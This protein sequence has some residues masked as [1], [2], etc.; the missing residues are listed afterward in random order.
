MNFIQGRKFLKQKEFGKALEIFKKIEKKNAK[1]QNIFFYLG[2]VY[3]ELNQYD[4]S[5]DYYNKF[6][7][8]QPNSLSALYNLALVKQ[9]TGKLEEAKAIYFK[10]LSI[11]K[12]NIRA[13]YG[14]YMLDSNFLSDEMFKD[15]FLI[16]NNNKL[17]LYDEGLINFLL[18]KKEKKNNEYKKE[19]DYLKDYHEKIFNYNYSYNISSQFYYNQIINK[20]FDKIRNEKVDKKKIN[21]ESLDP[22]Y[23]IG[24]PRSGSTLIESILTSSVENISTVGECHVVNMSILEQV[25]PKIYSKNF[26]KDKFNFEVNLE[27]LKKNI[28][29]KYFKLYKGNNNFKFVDKSLENFFNIEIIIKIFPNAKFIHT[30]RNPLDSVISIYQSML[31]DLSWAH[32]IENIL[33]YVDNYLKVMDSFKSK[34]KENIIDIKLENFTKNSEELGKL[35]FKFCKLSWSDN[36]L[37]FYERKNLYSKTLSF[38]QIRSKVTKYDQKQYEPY[39]HLLNPYKKKYKWLDILN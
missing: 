24:L 26:D 31:P 35:I 15:L 8:K 38:R 23:I 19:L 21:Q 30:F 1:D 11:N 14:L 27:K 33:I 22:I 5:I 12:F 34:Y 2:L 37:K 18:S 7:N 32:N 29:T 36:T 3:F 13:Y 39:F 4:K 20:Y 9:V 28:L 10:L 17:N 16:K 6:L 25:G